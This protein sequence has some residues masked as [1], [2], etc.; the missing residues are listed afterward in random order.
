MLRLLR[1][2]MCLMREKNFSQRMQQIS[3]FLRHHSTA[4][5][6]SQNFRPI[7]S[8]PPKYMQ[9]ERKR[10]ANFA[11]SKTPRYEI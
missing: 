2:K 9:P 5:I 10:F 3:R 6:K 7:Y 8:L 11:Q 1:S 4:K